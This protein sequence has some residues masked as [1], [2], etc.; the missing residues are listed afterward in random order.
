[1]KAFEILDHTADV[2]LRVYG[3]DL[4][5]LFANAALGMFS[6]MADLG[7]VEEELCFE[8]EAKADDREGLLVE[9]LNE[10]LYLSETKKILFRRAE[11]LKLEEE[12]T[13]TAK[14]YGEPIDLKKHTLREEI[15]ACTYHQLKIAKNDFF[16]AEV[17]LDV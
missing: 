16:H 9:W 11:I 1:M 6:L 17:V 3:R 7:G 15:K 8:V 5:E 12:K 10:L 14:A 13:L 2:G 4:E